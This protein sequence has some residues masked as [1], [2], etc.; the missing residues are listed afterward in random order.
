MTDQGIENLLSRYDVL[1]L[2]KLKY[3]FES[4]INHL[5]NELATVNREHYN[6]DQRIVLVDTLSSFADKQYFYNYLL[7][8]N[9]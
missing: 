4:P 6:S 7:G 2:N 5:Y 9:L 1:D 3:F 8:K